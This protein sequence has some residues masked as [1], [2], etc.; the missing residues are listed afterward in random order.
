MGQMVCPGG[1]GPIVFRDGTCEEVCRELGEVICHSRMGD[2]LTCLSWVVRGK[3]FTMGGIG[4]MVYHGWNGWKWF[5][6]C[7]MGEMVC[8]GGMR[9][10][11]CYGCMNE[12][13]HI[14][15][16]F[17]ETSKTQRYGKN[18]QVKIRVQE[19][20]GR[21]IGREITRRCGNEGQ[22][23]YLNDV[24]WTTLRF[25][26]AANSFI[27]DARDDG[28]DM[29]N[30]AFIL[31]QP[32]REFFVIISGNGDWEYDFSEDADGE[33]Y[34]RCVRKPFLRYV[35]DGTKSLVVRVISFAASTA[36]G[37]LTGGLSGFRALTY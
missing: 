4:E 20:N 18:Y 28:A 29:R 10:V 19:I 22:H 9:E 21:A 31:R 27:P 15:I 37:F 35:W 5:T 1:M 6:M 11:F 33:I 12:I 32:G 8:R 23:R 16:D 7:G 3:W 13:A 34:G 26:R 24:D 17:T 30:C 14:G 25:L 36:A 2:M